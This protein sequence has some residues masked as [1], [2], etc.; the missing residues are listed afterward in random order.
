MS[1]G[2]GQDPLDITEPPPCLSKVSLM[3]WPRGA[4]LRVKM[5]R[6]EGLSGAWPAAVAGS[7][8]AP[9]GLCHSP[10]CPCAFIQGD[11][12]STA[13]FR[14]SHHVCD[15]HRFPDGRLRLRGFIPGS[16][17]PDPPACPCAGLK[18]PLLAGTSGQPWVATTQRQ[19]WPESSWVSSLVARARLPRGGSWYEPAPTRRGIP[20]LRRAGDEAQAQICSILFLGGYL[21]IH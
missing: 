8:I 13:D 9:R 19:L 15:H 6:A 14:R 3:P 17:S 1:V 20:W 12:A 16:P 18:T 4:A 7:R 5:G 21:P 11:F 2:K 10:A